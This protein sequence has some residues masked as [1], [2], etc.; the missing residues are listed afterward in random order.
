M[1]V[2]FKYVDFYD[3]PRLIMFRYR[4]YLFLLGSY[5]DDQKDDYGENYLIE[6]LPSWVEKRIAES[7]W[8]VLE[9]IDRQVLG[10]IPVRDVIFDT[11]KRE[12]I[13]TTFLDK[14]IKSHGAR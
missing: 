6:I 7:S 10:E 8:E 14:Y 3:I 1:M 4:D 12:M 2:P 13:D 9:H 11:T 5:F